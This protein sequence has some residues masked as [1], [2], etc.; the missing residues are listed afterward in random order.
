MARGLLEVEEAGLEHGVERHEPVGGPQDPGR[1]VE[2]A[3]HRLEVGD[4][5]GLHEIGLVDHDH[6]GE[7]DL[8]HEQLHD[9]A[10]ILVVE[11]DTA[12]AEFVPRAVILEEVAG[13]D[14]RHERVEPCEGRQARPRLVGEGERLGHRQRLGDARA[15]DEQVVEAVFAG[16][17]RDLLEEILPQRAADAA[18]GKLDEFFLGAAETAG[19]RLRERMSDELRVDVHL[20]HVVDDHGHAPTLTI[21]EHVVQER[22]LARAEKPREHRHRQAGV[23]GSVGRTRGRGSRNGHAMILSRECHAGGDEWAVCHDPTAFGRMSG[24]YRT[25]NLIATRPLHCCCSAAATTPTIPGVRRA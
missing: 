23:G 11:P 5:V 1:G 4:V 19:G 2:P 21:G 22:R 7:L 15:L 3:E 16:E 17:L 20:A 13:V 25:C 18:V 12:V 9:V 10:G 6:V 24:L 14:D 8:V